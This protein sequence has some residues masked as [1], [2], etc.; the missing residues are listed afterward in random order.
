MSNSDIP[1]FPGSAP[2]K[3]LDSE[4]YYADAQLGLSNVLGAVPHDLGFVQST[5]HF[6]S[7][8]GPATYL[9]PSI[10]QNDFGPTRI[11]YGYL[12]HGFVQSAASFPSSH[13]LA[14]Y[15]PPAPVNQNQSRSKDRPRC[16]EHGCEGRAF[17]CRENYRRHLREKNG[18]SSVVCT[19]CGLSFSRKS[20]R[21]K[22]ILDGKCKIVIEAFVNAAEETATQAATR[23]ALI[24]IVG[25]VGAAEKIAE[26][27]E[28]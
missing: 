15:Q 2:F 1:V 8:H 6:L 22:H 21:D 26:G 24:G 16:F 28:S 19:I 12:D 18:S 4:A 11:N 17:S 20:N 13:G 7:S 23:P 27:Y 10:S 14:T 9:S 5:A 3:G 25:C